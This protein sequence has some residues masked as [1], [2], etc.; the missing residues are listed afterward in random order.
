MIPW[1]K[2]TQGVMKSNS[3]TFKKGKHYSPNTEFKSDKMKIKQ[4][5]KNNSYYKGGLPH[6]IIC[7]NE[8][9]DY[10][11]KICRNC[12]KMENHPNWQGGDNLYGTEF[13]CELKEQIRQ[14]DGN[15]CQE[16]FRGQDELYDKKGKKYKLMV[17]HIDYNKKNNLP[18]NL[19]SICISCHMKTNTNRKYWTKYFK[20]K[21]KTIYKRLAR[22][23][24]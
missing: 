23:M 14:R 16:C 21:I 20:K 24:R 5:G 1:N 11:T 10:R 17:H 7:G 15:R 2:N 3:G 4:L 8:L 22:N 18:I 13:N 12:L 9:N 6:C 19:I